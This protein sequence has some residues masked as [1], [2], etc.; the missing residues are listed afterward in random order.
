MEDHV[1]ARVRA[2]RKTRGVSQN[3]L[4]KAIG[5]TQPTLSNLEGGRNA[6][7][8]KILDIARALKVNALW[9]QDGIGDMD[10]YQAGESAYLVAESPEDL[11]RQLAEK[12]KDYLLTLIHDV[13]QRMKD[14]KKPSE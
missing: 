5:I 7:S 6:S 1:G 8:V 2:A 13:T 14:D 11:A 12:G 3:D 10:D 9:L 4:A